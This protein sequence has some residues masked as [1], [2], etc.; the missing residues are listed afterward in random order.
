MYFIHEK[1]A[2]RSLIDLPSASAQ[3]IDRPRWARSHCE[4]QEHA[5]KYKKSTMNNI[6]PAAL[7]RV[8]KC[9][10]RANERM[11]EKPPM[12]R[13][14]QARIQPKPRS[15]RPARSPP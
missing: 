8:H 4:V 9:G 2:V 11:G 10:K 1:Q 12:T 7:E 6:S 5:E 15:W 13:W 3:F 14:F